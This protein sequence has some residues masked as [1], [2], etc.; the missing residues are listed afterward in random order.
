MSVLCINNMSFRSFYLF[1]F[2]I[3][4]STKQLFSHSFF[5]HAIACAI[6]AWDMSGAFHIIEILPSVNL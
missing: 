2:M 4:A 5:R 3:E 1:L 6:D